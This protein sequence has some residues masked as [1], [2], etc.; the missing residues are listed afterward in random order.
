MRKIACGALLLPA[1]LLAAPALSADG[2]RD[3]RLPDTGTPA[4]LRGNIPAVPWEGLSGSSTPRPY[5]IPG[6]SAETTPSGVTILRG[7]GAPVLPPPP[8]EPEL[9]GP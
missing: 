2:G 7:A 8:S 3:W 4:V 1:V 6:I 5:P 9:G